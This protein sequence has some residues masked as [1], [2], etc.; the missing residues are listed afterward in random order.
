[1]G[2][3]A[4]LDR[5]C[6]ILQGLQLKESI[7]DLTKQYGWLDSTKGVGMPRM[8]HFAI[9][10]PCSRKG[11]L[12]FLGFTKESWPSHSSL[13][14]D[15][16]LS[17]EARFSQSQLE[18]HIGIRNELCDLVEEVEKQVGGSAND[19]EKEESV[20]IRAQSV[21]K[22]WASHPPV[23]HFSTC[24]AVSFPDFIVRQKCVIFKATSNCPRDND[25]SLENDLRNPQSLN[26]HIKR[27]DFDCAEIMTEA[28]YQD[29]SNWSHA[30]QRELD[31]NLTHL[32]LAPP[33]SSGT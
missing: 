5:I 1:M 25:S 6:E 27:D 7:A 31:G 29:L 32:M 13:H 26:W 17:R 30:Q 3:D 15:R 14:M 10:S 33:K 18:K 2:P 20:T 8:I 11:P 19:A 23:Y 16:K 4:A 24:R 21:R 12:L 22:F 9:G 28:G